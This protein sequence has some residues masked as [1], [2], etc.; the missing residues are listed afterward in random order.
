MPPDESPKIF[1]ARLIA[2]AEKLW[3][4]VHVFWAER[5]AAAAPEASVI[6]GEMKALTSPR[7]AVTAF[8]IHL[9]D[10]FWGKLSPTRVRMRLRLLCS[11]SKIN[12]ALISTRL[13]GKSGLYQCYSRIRAS[14]RTF[15]EE[16][17]VKN[18]HKAA[19]WKYFR[20]VNDFLKHHQILRGNTVSVS[21]WS[22]SAAINLSDQDLDKVLLSV[23]ILISLSV[24]KFNTTIFQLFPHEP[25]I[26]QPIYFMPEENPSISETL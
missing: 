23:W 24:Q 3:S 18:N 10:V 20:E 9:R 19:L 21:A 14:R 13:R 6:S 12:S 5:G 7:A 2:Q 25:L 15:H 1:S 16:N 26:G 22:S 11:S 8:I 4:M 17:R